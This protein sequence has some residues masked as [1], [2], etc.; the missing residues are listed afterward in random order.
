MQFSWHTRVGTACIS[1]CLWDFTVLIFVSP[2]AGEIS[3]IRI[4]WTQS[5]KFP[6]A[7]ALRLIISVPSIFSQFTTLALC[8]RDRQLSVTAIVMPPG[9]ASAW[10][11]QG[12][13]S[14]SQLPI[15]CSIFHPRWSRPNIKL[16]ERPVKSKTHQNH[17]LDIWDGIA[18]L[19]VN[20]GN[21]R[22]G[23]NN[24]PVSLS[25]HH[26][27]LFRCFPCPG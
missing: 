3:F 19:G 2:E 5:A 7:P 14:C 17:I 26:L 11:S 24:N 6:L 20:R 23:E 1:G 4:F 10:H 22:N 15:S 18:R 16:S 13:S 12:R 25:L 9:S 21:K 27:S 8:P